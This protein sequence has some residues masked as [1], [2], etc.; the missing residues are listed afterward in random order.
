[1]TDTTV[2]AAKTVTEGD[3][4]LVNGEWVTVDSVERTLGTV[5]DVAITHSGRWTIYAR[6]NAS[7]P[8]RPKTA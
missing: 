8:I 5:G 4:I 2:K 1:M 3:V 7:I 6:P